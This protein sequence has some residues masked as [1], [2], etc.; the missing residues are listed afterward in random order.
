MSKLKIILR[1]ATIFSLAL[2]LNLGVALAQEEPSAVT[3]DESVTTAQDES[4]GAT[5]E[6]F[7]QELET[8]VVESAAA[9]E[10]NSI[11]T[12]VLAVE[13]PKLLPDSPFYFFK[14]IGRGISNTFTF[15]SEKKAEKR[16][17]QA[18]ERLAETKAMLSETNS[19]DSGKNKKI[20]NSII[21]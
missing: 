9:T 1:L 12:E 6:I 16:L 17:D 5:E 11:S 21:K 14:E 2:T 3:E 7:S 20:T 8:P 13:E 4:A 19:E 18:A 15:S 10:D